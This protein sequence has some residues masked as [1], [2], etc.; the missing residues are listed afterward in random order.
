MKTIFL[1]LISAAAL[2]VFAACNKVPKDVV[3]TVDKTAVQ[4]GDTL[5]FIVTAG[6]FS[7]RVSATPWVDLYIKKPGEADFSRSYGTRFSEK[8][9]KTDLLWFWLDTTYATGT[10]SF[11]AKVRN[12]RDIDDDSNKRIANSNE[13]SVTVTQ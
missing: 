2:I 8:P 11:Y 6:D 13:I 3:I 4:I 12:C 1:L 7:S 9:Y 5:N 10:Y